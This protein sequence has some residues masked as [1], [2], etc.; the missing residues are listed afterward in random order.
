MSIHLARVLDLPRVNDVRGNL[1]FIEGDE[2]T[3]FPIR[4]VYYLYDVPGGASRG[5]HAHRQLQQLLIAL[6]GSFDVLLD[7]GFERTTISL[8][9]SFRALYVPT[10]VWRELHNFSS[11]AV[12]LS[13]ASEH[14]S[15]ADYVR[16][17]S[18]FRTWI[19]EERRLRVVPYDRNYLLA[20]RDWLRDPETKKLTRTPDFTDEAQEAWFAGLGDRLDYHVVGLTHEGQPAGVVGLKNIE[21]AE[22]EFFGYLGRKELWGQGLGRQLLEVAAILARLRKVRTLRLRVWKGNERAIRL[23]ER[24]GFQ[25]VEVHEEELVMRIAIADLSGGDR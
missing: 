11:G 10:R 12:C 9:R 15:E 4:R 16:D 7:D 8:N 25:R 20:S 21:T 6:S 14:Y 24:L 2:H 5:G 22:A 1:T 18:A 17:Y 19:A 3:P 23:Y 13:V